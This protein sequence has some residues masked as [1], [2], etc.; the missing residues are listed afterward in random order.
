WRRCGTRSS[1]TRSTPNQKPPPTP[2]QTRSRR[3]SPL[4]PNRSRRPRQNQPP[5][6]QCRTTPGPRHGSTTS[7]R[8][9]R[10]GSPRQGGD[11]V[12]ITIPDSP[13]G[14]TEILNDGD[15]LKELWASPE[16]LSEFIQGYAAAVDKSNRG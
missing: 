7:P 8:R 6:T 2:P 9:S 16:S 10:R 12:T 5:A 13:A 15:K 4:T 14:L 11:P 3:R 1:P